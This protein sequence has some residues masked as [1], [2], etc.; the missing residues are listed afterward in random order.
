MWGG[1]ND[2]LADGVLGQDR[3]AG[4]VRSLVGGTTRVDKVDEGGE[5][6]L[7]TLNS[8]IGMEVLERRIKTHLNLSQSK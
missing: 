8:S 4:T 2:W 7:V 6:R 3:G 5:G 1:I